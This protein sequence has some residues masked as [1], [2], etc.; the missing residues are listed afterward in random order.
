[1]RTQDIKHLINVAF[2]LGQ[3]TVL[4]VNKFA[5][6]FIKSNVDDAGTNGKPFPCFS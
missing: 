6:S 1:M 5:I 2:K 4:F 3:H